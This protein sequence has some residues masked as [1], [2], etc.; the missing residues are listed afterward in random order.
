MGQGKWTPTTFS[1]TTLATEPAKPD[2]P[3]VHPRHVKMFGLRVEWLTP[4]ENGSSIVSFTV[5]LCHDGSEVAVSQNQLH[6]NLEDTLEPGQCYS[7]QVRA[8]NQ[9]GAGP[10]SE[11]SEAAYTHTS[12][13]DPPLVPTVRQ[14]AGID[15]IDLDAIR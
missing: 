12:K 9:Q 3:V 10:W 14:P 1:T 8:S 15:W 4:N 2:P 7:F 5:R 6:L 13:A 11:E